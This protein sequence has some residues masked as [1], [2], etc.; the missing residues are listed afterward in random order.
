M[1]KDIHAGLVFWFLLSVPGLL[2]VSL[3]PLKTITLI[4]ALSLLVLAF[5]SIKTPCLRTGRG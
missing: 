2:R 4:L 3:L 5:S 1:K